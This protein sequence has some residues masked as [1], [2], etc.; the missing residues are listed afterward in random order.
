MIKEF[1]FN[2]DAKSSLLRGM[3]TLADAV[4]STLGPRGKSVIIDDYTGNGKPYI[5]K[6]GVTVAKNIGVEDKFENIGVILLQQA[7]LSTVNGVGDGT[8]TS[9]ILAYNMINYANDSDIS[10]FIDFKKGVEK[11]KEITL[12]AIKEC[13]IDVTDIEK[14]ATISANNDANIGKIIADTI[15]EIGSDGVITVEESNTKD[16]AVEI[17]KGMQ[18]EPGYVSHWFATD[19][20]T[21]EC[22]L[23]NPYILVTDQKIE[24]TRD[25]LNVAKFCIAERRPLLIIARDYDDEVIQNMKINHVQGNL[26]SC[27]VKTPLFGEYRKDFL[28]DICILTGAQI[29]TYDNGIELSSVTGDMLGSCSKIIV[30]KDN[31]TIVGGNGDKNLIIDRVNQIKDLL[32]KSNKED[33]FLTDQYRKRIA[34]LSSGIARIK[35]GGTS[36]L[37]MKEKKDRIDDAVCATKAAIEEGI[38]PGGGKVYYLAYNKIMLELDNYIDKNSNYVTG[39]LTIAHALKS[40]P[41]K[42]IENSGRNIDITVL[43]K[44]VTKK[45]N[46]IWLDSNPGLN[47]DLNLACNVANN[48]EI[49][50]NNVWLDLIDFKYK[51]F[52]ESGIVDPAKVVRVAFENALSV[53]DLFLSTNCLIVEKDIFKQI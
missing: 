40:I 5:T 2:E 32:D 4:G 51:D 47:M 48:H 22:I 34:K 46:S 25:I 14:V 36:E 33:N 37:D 35:V 21:G 3:K 53:L 10:D 23:E 41:L 44:I 50:Q 8:T 29:A 11:A 9:T 27:L 26:K 16:T 52:I 45:L 30:N 31:T 39:L 13:S 24:L 6:D 28:E 7:A 1:M 17:I 42:L 38:V 43:E 49:Q 18:F 19:K 20:T 15:K 12:D